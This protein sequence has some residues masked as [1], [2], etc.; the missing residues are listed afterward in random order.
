MTM[1]LHSLPG[2][3]LFL[4]IRQARIFL[5]VC[6]F[7]L[8]GCQK[9]VPSNP[10]VTEGAAFPSVRLATGTGEYVEVETLRG[11]MVVLNVWATWCSPCRKEMPALERLSRELDP[12]RFAVIGLSTDRDR[13]LAEEFLLK[14]GITF[15]NFFDPDGRIAQRLQLKIYPETFL[16]APDGILIRRVPGL[17]EWD[18]AEIIAELE[19]SHRQWQGA[20]DNRARS[21]Q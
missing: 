6:M 17:R 9:A 1:R 16:I 21:R 19:E 18:S 7:A 10:Q 11:R 3:Q 20:A 14:N 8:A 13:W 12:R 15:S 5:L 4:A 2:H